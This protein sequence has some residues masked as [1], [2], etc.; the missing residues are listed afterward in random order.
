VEGLAVRGETWRGTETGEAPH[1]QDATTGIRDG[2]FIAFDDQ[3]P[4]N[5]VA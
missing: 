4:V 3:H 1:R 2:H 5:G